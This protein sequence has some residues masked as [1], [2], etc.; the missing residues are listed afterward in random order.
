MSLKHQAFQGVVWTFSEQF[1]SQLIGF[2]INVVLA[3]L[4]LPTDFGII[5]L[6]AVIMALAKVFVDSGLTGSLIRT[7][8]PDEKDFSTVFWFNIVTAIVLY[9]LIY[10]TAPW[11]ADFYHQDLLTPLIRVYAVILIIDS[12]VAVQGVQF[13][14]EMDFKTNFKIQLPS[15]IIGGISGIGFAYYGFGAWALVY[16]SLIQNSIFTLQYWFYS[17]WRPSFIFDRKKFKH[18][19]SFGSKLMLSSLLDV[20]FNNIYTILIGKKFS[21]SELG[22]YSRADGL[23]QLPV[24]SIAGALHKVS[25]PLFAKISHDDEKLRDIYKK[26]LR[27][28]VFAIAPIIA[29]MVV[30]AEPL[31]RFLFTEKWL[32]TVPYLQILAIA[33]ILYPIHAY[34][35][36]ILQVI[37]RSDLFLKLEIF[38]KLLIVL[39]IAISLPFGIRG[40]LWGQIIISVLALFINTHYTA[41][42]LKYS[43]YAQLKDLFPS[44]A[45]ASICAV[46]VWGSDVLYFHN[47]T[48]IVR[49]LC[50]SLLYLLLYVG[51]EFLFKSK[52]IEVLKELIFNK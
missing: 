5:A 33:G 45:L 32:P 21:T 39:T 51:Y 44:L 48:D 52:E 49:L 16:S 18:H 36:N 46:V 29:L 40:L 30:A 23:K 14:K 24:N 47:L 6:F 3:R 41:K 7:Q 17:D 20:S 2:G 8:N 50:L 15:M 35:L 10:L 31:I 28:V 38:K 37:G 12:F 34:N 11:V 19:F 4:L 1:G 25:F 26:L 27:I 43:G 9:A 42:F 22:F 13:V